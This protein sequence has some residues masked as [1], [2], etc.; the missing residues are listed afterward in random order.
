MEVSDQLQAPAALPP[1]KAAPI[2]I[3]V[4]PR[5]GLDKMEKGKFLPLPGLQLRPLGRPGR[6]PPLYRLVSME[7]S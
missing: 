2:P 7:V 4:G 6:S 1:G 5:A 3:G